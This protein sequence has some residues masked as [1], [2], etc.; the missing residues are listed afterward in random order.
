[1]IP[2]RP[3][4]WLAV[5]FESKTPTPVFPPIAM[6]A[7]NGSDAVAI[8]VPYLITDSSVFETVCFDMSSVFAKAFALSP[9]LYVFNTVMV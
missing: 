3:A 4:H 8:S 6:A 2:R 1:M 7:A 9:K 5:N